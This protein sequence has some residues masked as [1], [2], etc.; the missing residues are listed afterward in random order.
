MEWNPGNATRPMRSTAVFMSSLSKP[1]LNSA[2][3]DGP[4][5]QLGLKRIL[6]SIG[7][8]DPLRCNTHHAQHVIAKKTVLQTDSF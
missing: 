3:G 4:P 1:A 6:Q 5:L 7:I 8:G 2:E